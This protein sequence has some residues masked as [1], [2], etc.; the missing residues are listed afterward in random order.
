MENLLF[1]LAVVSCIMLFLCI[2]CIIGD[3]IE[4]WLKSRK[5]KSLFSKE[6][7]TLGTSPVTSDFR[8]GYV[9]QPPLSLLTIERSLLA[10]VSPERESGA[11]PP[12]IGATTLL[13]AEHPRLNGN[14]CAEFM[15][16]KHYAT[17]RN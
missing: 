5:K 16:N 3:G 11:V 12:A 7:K 10:Q 15:P 13:T 4:C 1:Y 17:R 6:S 2:G 9:T 14:L 8:A